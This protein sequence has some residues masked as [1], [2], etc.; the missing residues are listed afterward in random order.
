MD[1]SVTDA[2]KRGRAPVDVVENSDV[3]LGSQEKRRRVGDL[4]VASV[5]GREVV[6]WHAQW[7]NPDWKSML[8]ATQASEAEGADNAT[9][10]WVSEESNRALRQELTEDAGNFYGDL[11]RAAMDRELNAWKHFKVFG[12]FQEGSNSKSVVNNR[13]VPAWKW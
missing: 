2:G 6:K 12:P 9:S 7:R 13:R 10:G 1:T 8:D 3:P 5:A 4:H 11:A